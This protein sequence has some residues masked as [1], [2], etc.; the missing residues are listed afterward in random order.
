V[1]EGVGA[2]YCVITCG[3]DK[4]GVVVCRCVCVCV[5]VCVGG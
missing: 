2:Q 4:L 1:G 5:C 3:D